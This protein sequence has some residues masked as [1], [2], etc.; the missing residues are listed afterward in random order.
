MSFRTHPLFALLS[1][2][3]TG[4]RRKCRRFRWT[5][6]PTNSI[7]RIFS[8]DLLSWFRFRSGDRLRE[9]LLLSGQMIANPLSLCSVSSLTNQGEA[10]IATQGYCQLSGDKSSSIKFSLYYFLHAPIFSFVECYIHNN[11]VKNK[12]PYVRVQPIRDM[13]LRPTTVQVFDFYVMDCRYL[14]IVNY[15]YIRSK[16]GWQIFLRE[17]A[18]IRI[19][20]R[21]LVSFII[22]KIM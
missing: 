14:E 12:A 21:T 3:S 7:Y 13:F 11:S 20:R 4:P 8:P 15:L 17:I 19:A 6:Y 5:T 9:A 1:I 18:N 22:C 10:R 16:Q 2:T